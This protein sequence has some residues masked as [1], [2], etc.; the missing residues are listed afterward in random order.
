MVYWSI[1]NE[2][3]WPC[4]ASQCLSLVYLSHTLIC[5]QPWPCTS[6]IYPCLLT[7]HA[8]PVFRHPTAV[9]YPCMDPQPSVYSS[10]TL[11]SPA[12]LITVDRTTLVARYLHL[13]DCICWQ[14]NSPLLCCSV[15]SSFLAFLFEWIT[16]CT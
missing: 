6:P 5:S 2:I 7:T 13:V 14:K 4:L 10:Q 3:I 15:M 1:K 11:S 8:S 12:C 9:S 16:G